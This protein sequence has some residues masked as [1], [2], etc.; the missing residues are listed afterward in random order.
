MVISEWDSVRVKSAVKATRFDKPVDV[1]PLLRSNRSNGATRGGMGTENRC[2]SNHG[3]I[4][5]K[6]TKRDKKKGK[7]TL[8]NLMGYD[9]CLNFA[10]NLKKKIKKQVNKYGT[11]AS[12]LLESVEFILE[13]KF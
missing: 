13:R 11:R 2:S 1:P 10:K 5:G 4:V 9:K 7:A 6:P 3:K 8:V 12:D